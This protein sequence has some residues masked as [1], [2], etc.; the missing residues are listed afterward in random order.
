MARGLGEFFEFF[1]E[2]L[3]DIGLVGRDVQVDHTAFRDE[4]VDG[5]V[6]AETVDIVV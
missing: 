5:A 4:I 2:V 3:V 6:G 1:A